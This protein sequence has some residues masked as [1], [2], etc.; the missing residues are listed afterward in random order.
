MHEDMVRVNLQGSKW[1]RQFT[2]EIYTSSVMINKITPSVN[3]I[4]WWKSLYIAV[5]EITK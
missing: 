4:Y 3:Y 5:M 2:I 1:I